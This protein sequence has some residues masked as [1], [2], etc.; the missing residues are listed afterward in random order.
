VLD[1]QPSELYSLSP[2]ANHRCPAVPFHLTAMRQALGVAEDIAPSCVDSPDMPGRDPQRLPAL[3][4]GQG[5]ESPTT[6]N[7]D[8]T[9][10]LGPEKE[11]TNLEDK[12]SA[13][14]ISVVAR[15]GGPQPRR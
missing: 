12:A 11:S 6:S 2:P 8:V 14:R 9:E 15:T 10:L 3:H 1:C 5:Q 13:R 4:P 7:G